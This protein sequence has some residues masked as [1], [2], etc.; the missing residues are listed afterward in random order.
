MNTKRIPTMVCS[1][2]NEIAAWN[3]AVDARKAQR[4][5]RRG[6][7]TKQQRRLAVRAVGIRQH[8]KDVKFNRADNRASA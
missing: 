2:P 1:P 5:V 7:L 4:T 6:D 3:A 8:R